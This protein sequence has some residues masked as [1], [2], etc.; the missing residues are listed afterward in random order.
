V[1]RKKP[2]RHEKKIFF[3]FIRPIKLIITTTK[4]EWYIQIKLG[5]KGIVRSRGKRKSYSLVTIRV[6]IVKYRAKLIIPNNNRYLA[7]APA[8]NSTPSKN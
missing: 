1:A 3:D 5:A 6:S 8:D 4:K 7:F 2:E